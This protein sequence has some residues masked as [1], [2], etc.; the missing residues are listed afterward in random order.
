MVSHPSRPVALQRTAIETQEERQARVRQE[1]AIIAEA[2]AD[3]D[4][5]FGIEFEDMEAW[6]D[7]L[8]SSPDAPLPSPKS[9]AASR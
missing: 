7:E 2:E 4:A 6:L 5:G 9:A 1:A 8:E 3:I